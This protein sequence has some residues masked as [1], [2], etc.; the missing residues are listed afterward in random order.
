LKALA[1]DPSVQRI[2]A[3]PVQYRPLNDTMLYN[4]NI[5]PVHAGQSPLPQA[6]DG[7]GVVIGIIDTGIDFT[8]PDFQ[9]STGSTRIKFLWDQKL[10]A[11]SN[12]PQPYN[13]GQEWDNTGIDTGGAAAHNDL[14]YW[15]HGTHVAGIAAGD[16]S[17]VNNFKG[18]A[19]N[20][21]IIFVA[22]DFSNYSQGLVDAVDYI[23]AKAQAMGKPC[24]IN[25]SVG[26]Y[27]GSHDG[28]DLTAQMIDNMITAQNGR[29]LVAAV[30]NAGSIRYHLGYPVNTDTSFT[31]FQYNTSS[32]SL[33][34]QLWADTAD[35]QNVDFSIGADQPGPNWSFRGAIPFSDISSHLNV[36]INDTLYN[37]GNRI[38]V[39]QTY[40]ELLGGVYSMEFN[41]IPDS[42]SYLWR[43]MTTGSGEFDLWNFS[44]VSSGLPST[45]VFPDIAYYKMPDTMKTL[46]SSFQCLDNV[47]TVGN[48]SNR[49]RHLDYNNNLQIDPSITPGGLFYTSSSGPT[50]DGRIK[51]DIAASGAYT[52]SC[53]VL[54]M[55]PNFI[56]NAPEVLA[57]G[58]Y[59]VTGGGSSAAS[60]IVAGI[61]ALYLQANPNADHAQ[62]KNAITSCARQDQFTGSSL[63]NNAWGYGK[64]DAYQAIIGCTT[65]IEDETAYPSAL[66]IYPN[67]SE[68]DITI[69]LEIPAGRGGTITVY[70]AIGKLVRTFEVK[71]SGSIRM[72]RKDLGPGLYFFTLSSNGHML[73]TEKLVIL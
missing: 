18:A 8:H 28:L 7:T 64:A 2:E 38:G 11:A 29:A 70:N 10:A 41:I 23:Y 15:G 37:N 62:V 71:E 26:S 59:H 68:G 47:I 50:R 43:L 53:A 65:G 72:D 6:Y 48:Y 67:P 3:N 14:T 32:T 34:I 57:Q 40:A 31:W 61:A 20:A 52:I 30:G 46:V 54:S 19:P 36:L 39:V 4:N 45:S 24:V 44:M 60:P 56:A 5:V 69:D 13:Y 22:L 35:F 63:P 9:D 25:A 17:A 73:R 58:G 55:V 12:T 66:L 49:D 27:S 51:P 42:T 21:D 1:A 16:G 33:Y